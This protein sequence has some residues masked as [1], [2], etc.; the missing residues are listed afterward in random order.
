[1]KPELQGVVRLI[2]MRLARLASTPSGT[3]LVRFLTEMDPPISTSDLP[4]ILNELTRRLGPRVGLGYVPPV[5]L[6][7]LAKIAEGSSGGVICDPWAGFGFVLAAIRQVTQARTMIAITRNES[8]AAIGRL[9]LPEGK[10]MVG[11]ALHILNDISGEI[12]IAVSVLPFG[13]RHASHF[14]L[15]AGNGSK[16]E[17]QG[18]LGGIILAAYSDRLASDGLG[19]FVVPPAFFFS[20]QS[21]LRR[22]DALGLGIVAALALPS[23]AFAPYMNISTYLVV[24]KKGGSSR[25]FVAQLSGDMN[26]NLQII[27]NFKQGREGATLELGRI[28]DPLS[29]EGIG[30]L[31]TSERLH[32]AERT[33]GYPATR[34]EELATAVTLGRPRNDFSFADAQNAIFIPLVG[35]SDVVDSMA[36]GTLKAQNY[37]QIVLD[38]AAR[39]PAL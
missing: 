10:W 7:V 30:P 12:N 22:F 16:T 2:Q 36:E 23:G 28:V 37:A 11:D 25:M 9:L 21:V 39:T 14:S 31:R 29:F 32:Q 19:L 8:E 33:F 15:T 35:I 27:E 34:L 26:T 24:V 13:A 5:L 20:S 1:M 3:E 38:P 17:L 18:D 6:G 4:E